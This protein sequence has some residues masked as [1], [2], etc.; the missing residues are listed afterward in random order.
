[1]IL[2]RQEPFGDRSEAIRRRVYVP[3]VRALSF[4]S[5]IPWY[6]VHAILNP[7]GVRRPGIPFWN[8][9][10]GGS[11]CIDLRR[12]GN[13]RTM[14]GRSMLMVMMLSMHPLEDFLNP[15]NN[16]RPGMRGASGCGDMF[17]RG[18]GS[19]SSL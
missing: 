12:E 18:T 14:R 5:I 7:S 13:A 4:S 16:F 17:C 19:L 1:M 11:L 15:S 10:R 2:K 9:S 6:S 8:C 3:T